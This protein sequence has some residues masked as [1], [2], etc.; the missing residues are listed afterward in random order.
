MAG[1]GLEVLRDVGHGRVCERICGQVSSGIVQSCGLAE[2]KGIVAKGEFQCVCMVQEVPGP[3]IRW[4]AAATEL[5]SRAG[6]SCSAGVGRASRAEQ[7]KHP[8]IGAMVQRS[9]RNIMS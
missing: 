2:A 7:V 6:A 4:A 1:E 8:S 3:K 5:W 9:Q